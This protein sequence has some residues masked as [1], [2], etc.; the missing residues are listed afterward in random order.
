M[1]KAF[2][3]SFLISFLLF[4]LHG[5]A[6]NS[7]VNSFSNDAST[8][9]GIQGSNTIG[10][11][12][13]PNLVK[14]YL[15]FKGAKNVRKY[16]AMIE[17]ELIVEA[18]LP[19]SGKAVKVLISAQGSSTGFKALASNTAQI[20][21]A[22]RP[23]KNKEMSMLQDS[24]DMLSRENEYIIGIDGVAIIVHP[25]STIDTLS[26]SKI[27][28]IFSG[29]YLDWSELGAVPGPINVYARN[30]NS[31]TWD[32]FKSMVLGADNNLV[33]TAERFESNNELSDK[34]SVD[35]N[36]IGFVGLNSVRQSK[37]VAVSDG[38]TKALSP[39][40]LTVATED[41]ALS[42]RLFM[43]TLGGSDNHFVNEFL[44]Y[45]LSNA[46][47]K[48]VADAGFISQELHA[49]KPTYYED[50]PPPFQTLT[51]NSLRL[52]INFR[53]KEG[54]AKLD[55]KAQEDLKRLV[56]YLHKN[57]A[58][59]VILIGFGDP[60]RSIERSKLLSK[61]RAMAVRRELVR[62]KIYP[63]KAVGFGENFPVASAN[64]LEGR[65]KNRRVEVW[66]RPK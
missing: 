15:Q 65:I 44:E 12:M 28:G 2:P 33:S 46:G 39:N 62:H 49:V 7:A 35:K 55:N 6:N 56:S 26:L 8:L 22:S 42:R 29:R 38:S 14:G 11:V 17:N 41:Y 63:D 64:H 23:I 59:D 18:T 58:L 57:Q 37:S 66:V 36:G 25:N 53:F 32:S 52:T 21:A 4:P 43:Y 1:A 16:N 13:A 51:D 54:S 34:V 61:L 30:D 45:V 47:Q 50:L 24:T 31:G 60:K 9:F 3:L 19:E 27:A 20:A 10:A 5:T 48:I 40:K